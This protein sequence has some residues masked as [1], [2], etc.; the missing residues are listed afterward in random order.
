MDI[1]SKA[2]L[3]IYTTKSI[4][5]GSQSAV[6][7]REVDSWHTDDVSHAAVFIIHGRTI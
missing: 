4:H 1:I 5:S 6:L 7:T 2:Q 3:L